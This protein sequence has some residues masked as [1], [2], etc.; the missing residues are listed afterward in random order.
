MHPLFYEVTC[1]I[2]RPSKFLGS[3]LIVLRCDI[4]DL[5][6]KDLRDMLYLNEFNKP[7]WL[8]HGFGQEL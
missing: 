4:G 3:R 7:D 6:P 1:W 8:V 2:L 5:E